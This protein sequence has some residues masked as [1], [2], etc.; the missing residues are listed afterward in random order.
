MEI[1]T[2]YSS[3]IENMGKNN[4]DL[5]LHPEAKTEFS[6]AHNF[7]KDLETLANAINTRPE[8]EALSLA[9]NEY[10]Y[11]LLSAAAGNYRHAHSSL[12]L[13]IELSLASIQFSAN[14]LKLRRWIKGD[15]DVNWNS[16]TSTD[17]GVFSQHFLQAF[18]SEVDS[19]GRQY[20]EIAAAVY[21]ECSEFVHGN[22]HTHVMSAPEGFK[23]ESL[24]EWINRAESA[25]LCFVFAFAGR[26]LGV[27]SQELKSEIEHIMLE[28]LGSIT[29]IQ[30]IYSE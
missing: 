13:F 15:E 14:E 11:A 10:C 29:S 8:H 21:R 12:R 17:N 18:N 19:Y 7:S 4:S 24:E 20:L 25:Y 26:Y 22:H 9:I 16:I 28:N 30:V 23:F 6:K 2:F 27:A 5:F 1:D 3:A